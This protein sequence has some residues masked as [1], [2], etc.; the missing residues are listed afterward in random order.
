[1]NT[2]QMF[3]IFDEV[4]M[5]YLPPFFLPNEGMAHRTFMDCVG[6]ENHAFGKHPSNYTLYRIG[7]FDSTTGE[8]HPGTHVV[9]TGL[10]A[11]ARLAHDREAADQVL[12]NL[13]QEGN[14]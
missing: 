7:E 2:L 1:M 6:D 12:L 4:A 13:A 14:S 9:C 5:A 8:L 11:R 10:E 3:S